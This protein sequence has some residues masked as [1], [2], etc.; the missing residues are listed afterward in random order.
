MATAVARRTAESF[1]A[2]S[3]NQEVDGKP[4]GG[5]YVPLARSGQPASVS[6]PLKRSLV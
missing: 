4:W 1:I 2:E 5:L 3:F 6:D